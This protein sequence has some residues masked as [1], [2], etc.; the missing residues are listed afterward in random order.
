MAERGPWRRGDQLRR[1]P[2]AMQCPDFDREGAVRSGSPSAPADHAARERLRCP[3][4]RVPTPSL[5]LFRS[6]PPSASPLTCS[7]GPLARP[8]VG[9]P[10]RAFVAQREGRG[11]APQVGRVA[12][13]AGA[14]AARRH[15]AR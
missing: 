5:C 4:F 9:R 3:L 7:A 8:A 14:P 10:S 12:R 6:E 15:H 11:M 2:Q 1:C 13:T